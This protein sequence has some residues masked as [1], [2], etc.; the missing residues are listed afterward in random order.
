MFGLIVVAV[1]TAT[2]TSALSTSIDSFVGVEGNK[3]CVCETV[4]CL[5]FLLPSSEKCGHVGP[6]MV[7]HY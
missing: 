1:F 5:S 7:L 3:V 6:S 2:A 4:F